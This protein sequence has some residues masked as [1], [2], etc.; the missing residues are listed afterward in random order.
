MSVIPLASCLQ[1]R[2]DTDTL[3]AGLANCFR[4]FQLERVSPLQILNEAGS[5]ASSA[6]ADIVTS[7]QC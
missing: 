4:A 5:C 3:V 6:P 1:A 2:H 7:I